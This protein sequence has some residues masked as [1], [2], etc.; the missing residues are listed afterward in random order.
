MCFD[1][2]VFALLP[3]GNLL[4]KLTDIL[5][6]TASLQ[7]CLAA[8]WSLSIALV[9]TQMRL[10]LVLLCLIPQPHSINSKNPDAGDNLLKGDFMQF[11][12]IHEEPL[13]KVYRSDPLLLVQVG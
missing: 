11:L 1:P 3:D 5:V 9:V 2:C 10:T 8:T 12:P 4:Y 13:S 7:H 6:Y